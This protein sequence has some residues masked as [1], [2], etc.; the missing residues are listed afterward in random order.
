MVSYRYIIKFRG[1]SNEVRLNPDGSAADAAAFQQQ[2][3][4]NSNLMAQLFQVKIVIVCSHLHFCC[5]VPDP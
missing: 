1:S 4:N 5:G 2:V 3:R